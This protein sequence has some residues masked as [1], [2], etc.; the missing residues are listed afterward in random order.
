MNSQ[1][2]WSEA[3]DQG[4]LKPGEPGW[5]QVWGANPHSIRA[6][7]LV[8]SLV[9][10]EMVPTYVADLFPSKA[11]PMR[12]GVVTDNGER[13]TFGALSKIVL[14]RRGTHNMLAD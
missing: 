12:V 5:W 14:L 1:Q 10:D 8:L 4:V 9:D 11:A 6:G 3:Q 2:A 13:V 7:D